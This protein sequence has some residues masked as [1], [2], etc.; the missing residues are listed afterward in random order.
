MR[1]RVYG[2]Y[3][4]ECLCMWV[5]LCLWVRERLCI[6]FCA[7]EYVPVSESICNVRM[8]VCVCLREL[9]F[10]AMP[11][12]HNLI[13][14]SHR[15]TIMTHTVFIYLINFCVYNSH[16]LCIYNCLKEKKK[17]NINIK[18]LS[19]FSLLIETSSDYWNMWSCIKFNKLIIL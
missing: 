14:L 1:V 5:Y 3:V 17:Y 7:C 19:S 4:S 8:S 13:C 16:F 18:M 9:I 12:R 2:G 6:S 15:F 10:Y 11:L